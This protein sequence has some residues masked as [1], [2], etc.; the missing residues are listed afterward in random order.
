MCDLACLLRPW[1]LKTKSV[2]NSVKWAIYLL[3]GNEISVSFVVINSVI[4]KSRTFE[5]RLR[6]LYV[7][8]CVIETT[9]HIFF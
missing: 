7:P 1:F 6:G 2:H 8:N 3:K 9:P 5:V 4:A